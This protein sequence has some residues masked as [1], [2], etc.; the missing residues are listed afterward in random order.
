MIKNASF[1]VFLILTAANAFT[2]EALLR[3]GFYKTR[4]KADEILILPG[5]A[6]DKKADGFRHKHGYYG[7]SAWSGSV[8][9]Q[10]IMFTATGTLSGKNIYFIVDDVDAN[11]IREKAGNASVSVGASITYT[12]LKYREFRDNTGQKWEWHRDNRGF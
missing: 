11:N 5:T 4:G 12:I 9:D 10:K 7:M 3:P 1:F 6:F 2:Q 8:K